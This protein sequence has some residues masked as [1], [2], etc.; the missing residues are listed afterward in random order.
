[1]FY[2]F[3]HSIFCVVY[4]PILNFTCLTG[5]TGSRVTGGLVWIHTYV[6]VL[7]VY[8]MYRMGFPTP[9]WFPLPFPTRSLVLR[10]PVP[11]ITVYSNLVDSYHVYGHYRFP[12]N[13]STYS[14]QS[15]N[16]VIYKQLDDHRSSSFPSTFSSVFRSF[17]FH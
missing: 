2:P 17:L 4:L 12:I 14:I 9:P 6:S 1:M 11:E 13:Q 16:R 3:P 7:S 15:I 8:S 5:G 10:E